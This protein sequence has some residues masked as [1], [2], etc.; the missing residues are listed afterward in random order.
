MTRLA[1]TRLATRRLSMTRPRTVASLLA[2]TGCL[3]LVVLGGCRRSA[4]S[5]DAASAAHGAADSGPATAKGD[6]DSAA[7]GGAGGS[8]AAS[9]STPVVAAKTV[10]VTA[11]SFVESVTGIGAVAP[12]PGHYAEL[13]APA[14]ARVAHIY[15]AAGDRVA[16]GDS[17]V[18]FEHAPFD[19]A[20][21]GAA[22]SL[23]V[24]E[25]AYERVQRLAAAGI[26]PR[27]DVDQAAADLAQARTTA[28]N[29]QRAQQLAT[30]RAPLGG[31]VTHLS[32]VLG[33]TVDQTQ[34]VVGVADP[35]TLDLVFN[36]SPSD[37]ARVR[38]GAA[39][40]LNAGQSESGE[41]L[42]DG[43]VRTVGAALD[44]ATRSLPVRARLTRPTRALR[45]GETVFGRIA[46]TV[47]P[48]A[49]VV[50]VAA[51]VPEGDGLKVFVVGKNGLAHA[52]PVTVGG[53]TE[54]LA[55]ITAGLQ[56]GDVVV[57]EGAYGVEDSAKVVP[58]K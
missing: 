2:R 45:I 3:A 28:I 41:R 33:A 32:A 58:V 42:G 14:P 47:K 6:S 27:K 7:K 21:A 49:I 50:P 4:P 29:A 46:L 1:L 53:R 44:S 18:A 8:A 20:A 54:A 23:T 10:V 15:V 12:R 34:S 37:A 57:T 38:P 30:L 19:A 39:V 55:E 35:G 26:V 13:A 5:A 31:V 52:Q 40:T 51:L 36:L 16:S 17:L 24:A 43:V 25:R 48:H 56:P 11:Q 9:D 22:A